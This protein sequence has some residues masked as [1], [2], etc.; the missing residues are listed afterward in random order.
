VPF[1]C[2]EEWFHV[3]LWS[4]SLQLSWIIGG[5]VQA[6]KPPETVRVKKTCADL[7]SYKS[8]WHLQLLSEPKVVLLQ[9]QPGSFQNGTK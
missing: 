2:N 6:T 3:S 7:S 1:S 5:F 4:V 8:L 9:Q